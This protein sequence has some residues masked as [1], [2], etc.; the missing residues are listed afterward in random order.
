MNVGEILPTLATAPVAVVFK[1]V[2]GQH[3]IL[4]DTTN[5]RCLT[6]VDRVVEAV[7]FDIPLVSVVIL[8]ITTVAPTSTAAVW[9]GLAAVLVP[10]A[11]LSTLGR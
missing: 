4:H 1:P 2:I 11:A 5:E 6:R 8:I 7:L 3:P 9:T 10:R